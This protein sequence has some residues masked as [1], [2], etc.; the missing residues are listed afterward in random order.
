MWFRDI[1]SK[2]FRLRIL[3]LSMQHPLIGGNP[4]DFLVPILEFEISDI[5]VIM[6]LFPDIYFLK[7]YWAY[8]VQTWNNEFSW[9]GTGSF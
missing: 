2:T 4:L 8:Q 1:Y 5:T 6:G 9:W 7:N 3:K